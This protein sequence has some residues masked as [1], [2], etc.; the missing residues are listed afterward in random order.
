MDE[1]L[2]KIKLAEQNFN[3]ADENYIDAA[4]MDLNAAEER[5]N[6]FMKEMKEN[7]PRRSNQ[8]T[9]RFAR[10]LSRFRGQGR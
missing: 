6:I 3:Y 7:E 4:I 8:P 9:G 2:R 1:H 5:L 10:A